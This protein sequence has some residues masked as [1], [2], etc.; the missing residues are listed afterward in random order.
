[1]G[2]EK[3]ID[4]LTSEKLSSPS[5]RALRTS[6]VLVLTERCGAVHLFRRGDRD[7]TDCAA[8]I[9]RW[10]STTSLACSLATNEYM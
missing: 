5:E 1:M 10:E 8:E 3:E 6:T 2:R 9:M 7:E 4:D